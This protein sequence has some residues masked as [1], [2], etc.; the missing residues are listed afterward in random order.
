VDQ[1]KSMLDRLSDLTDGE[2]AELEGLILSEFQSVEKED[3]TPQTVDSMTSLADALDSVRGETTRRTDQ[4]SALAQKAAEA[5]AR[6]KGESNAAAMPMMD[7]EDDTEAPETPGETP[8]PE[9]IAETPEAPSDVPAVAPVDPNAPAVNPVDAQGNPV[10]PDGTPADAESPAEDVPGDEAEP[11]DPTKKKPA[12][13]EDGIELSDEEWLKCKPKKLSADGAELADEQWLKCKPKKGLASDGAE[14]SDEEW[15]TYAPKDSIELSINEWLA[16]KKKKAASEDSTNES[17]LSTSTDTP[18]VAEL[19]TTED[20]TAE[21]SADPTSPMEDA[22]TASGTEPQDA[23]V[24]VTPPADHLPTPTSAATL[25]ITAGADIPGYGA[26]STLTDM[27]DVA[28]AFSKRLHTLRG[29]TAGGSGEQYTIATMNFDY[30]EARRLSG[31]DP[32]N[33]AK[34]QDVVSLPALTAAAGICAPLTTIYD[35]NTVGITDRPIRDAL[36]RFNA[37]RGGVRLFGTPT[38]DPDATGIWNTS[39]AATK[40]CGDANCAE[41]VEVMV[42]AVY[43]CLKFSNFTNRFFPEMIKANTDLALIAHAKLAEINLLQQVQAGSIKVTTAGN[44]AGVARSLLTTVS[45]AAVNLRRRYRLDSRQPLHA[46]MPDFARDMIR[47]DLAL[48][49]P[50]DGLDALTVADTQ[51]EAFFRARNINVTW[52]IETIGANGASIEPPAQ[53]PGALAKFEDKVNFALYPEGKFLFLDGGTLD[54]GVVRDGTMV[55]ANEYSTFVE[56]FE[57]VATVAGAEALWVTA[58]GLCLSGA[59]GELVSLACETGS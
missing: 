45:Q 16:C 46:L 19:S 29:V 58:T 11:V 15:L 56:T 52:T 2:I 28:K 55:A 22:V 40:T 38:L 32:S 25:T 20:P 14:L 53:A 18:A 7:P 3:P 30:P 48:Q 26:G 24:V 44:G 36:A 41:P 59:A 27:L 37:D 42:D 10:N 31:D 43:S 1:I 57:A 35:V 49:A 8:D 6:V 33:W 54:L 5:S 17:E 23:G 9:D 4:Q 21:L 39:G 13:A 34:I 12:F 51:V 47:A 50:G